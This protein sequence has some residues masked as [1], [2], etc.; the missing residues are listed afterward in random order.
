MCALKWK[1]RAG[2]VAN[3]ASAIRTIGDF[4]IYKTKH[5]IEIFIIFLFLHIQMKN[6]NLERTY[7]GLKICLTPPSPGTVKTQH[8]GVKSCGVCGVQYSQVSIALSKYFLRGIIFCNMDDFC[9]FAGV[10]GIACGLGGHKVL[11]G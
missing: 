7:L 4:L 10:G 5:E 3:A 11:F 8:A 1:D 2:G 9:S 6:L